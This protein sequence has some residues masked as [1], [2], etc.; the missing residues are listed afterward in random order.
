MSK[1]FEM[2]TGRDG[3]EP[4]SACGRHMT[5][6]KEGLIRTHG[7]KDRSVW[8]PMNCRGSGQPPAEPQAVAS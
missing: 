4:C 8:P 7:A 3:R 5:I 2:A 6:T 1:G